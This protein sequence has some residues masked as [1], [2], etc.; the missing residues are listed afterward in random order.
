MARLNF[1]IDDSR[2]ANSSPI[3]R[4]PNPQFFTVLLLVGLACGAVAAAAAPAASGNP[5]LAADPDPV[6]AA[7][8]ALLPS[9]DRSYVI[10]AA[11]LTRSGRRLFSL[12]PVEPDS[13][14]RTLVIVGGLDGRPESTAAVTS[15]LK[16]WFT[17][18]AARQ[19][20][21]RW[22]V[23]AVPCARPDAC[24]AADNS[25][26]TA[27]SSAALDWPPA[28]GFYNAAEQGE[29]RYLWRWVA[30]QAPDL[31]VELR[32][33]TDAA[34]RANA[35]ASSAI[36]GASPAPPGSLAAALAGTP[37][38]LP[39]V[40]ALEIAADRGVPTALTELLRAAPPAA[41][42][43]AR[44][45]AARVARPPLDVARAMA[46]RYPE[47]PGMSYI[48]ALSWTG[49]L[50]L[51]ALTGNPEWGQR[52]RSQMEPFLTGAKP[53]IP[54]RPLLTAMA[55]HLAFADLAAAG[56]APE[57]A[58]LAR[59]AADAILPDTPD[60]IVRF[61][62]GWTDD[63]FMAS[64]VLTRVA[65]A[66]GDARYADTVARLLDASIAALQ[67]PDGLFVHAASA[68][69]AWGRGNGFAAFGLTEALLRLPAA[70]PAR[71]R[72]LDAFRRQMRAMRERQAPD[73]M[74]REVVD[75]PGSYRE[76]TVTAMTLTA[77]ARGVAHGWLDASFRPAIDRAWRGLLAH[78]AE[79]GTLV[80][81]CTGT[82]AGPQ[83]QYYLDRAAITGPDDRG[84]AMVLTAALEMGRR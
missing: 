64:S 65:A 17:D 52:A 32:A 5:D 83:K 7:L 25:A 3:L 70:W 67:R 12:E 47:A 30:M 16:W 35:L 72:V 77:M 76:L 36:P 4:L 51:S 28:D 1:R 8:R 55:G 9:R 53:A 27:A 40:A 79:D 80:D 10:D 6:A 29:A 11:G 37:S 26:A 31:V 44:A 24:A 14:R 75:E 43:L 15:F 66:T 81:V 19:A 39:P 23:A 63:M 2:I 58:A 48:S 49:A 18:A 33:G 68:P 56:G 41:S 50:R 71:P 60:A 22:Q 13:R 78:V 73:G 57:A 38:G 82:G 20:R 84:G 21:D 54:E 59:K 46:G 45:I 42:P 74:W 69:H 61:R 34:P 62:T